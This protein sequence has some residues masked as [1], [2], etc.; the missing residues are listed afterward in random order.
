MNNSENLN[1]DEENSEKKD[2]STKM[3]FR[4]LFHRPLAMAGAVTLIVIILLAVFADVIAPYDWATI[5]TENKFARPSFEHLLGTDQYGRDIFSR[6]IYGGRWSLTLGIASTA[7]SS[8]LGI[9][10]GAI[11]GYCG[12][13]VDSIIM[14]IIDVLQCIPGTLMT[15]CI[16]C[17]LGTGLFNTILAMSFQ[18]IWSTARFLRGNILS[19]REQEYVEAAKAT[20]VS[21][22][23][24]VLHYILPNS[25][26]PTLLQICMG[27]GGACTAAAGLAFLGLGVQAPYPEWGAMLNEG[28][29]YLRYYPN[30]LLGPVI[31]LALLVLATNFLGDGIRDAMDPRMAE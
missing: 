1:P 9:I 17:V 19:V 7:I 16:A 21:S 30:M 2:T 29:S 28:R 14:R 25:I 20:N 24:T 10:V 15:L 11:A 3:F 4:K 12:G 8:V 26:Q 31:M 5:D 18:G 6:L 27:I 13:A 23:K 22:F